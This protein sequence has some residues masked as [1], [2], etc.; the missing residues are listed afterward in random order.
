MVVIV[1]PLVLQSSMCLIALLNQLCIVVM[2]RGA[3]F[4]KKR[5]RM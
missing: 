5:G 3:N 1:E 2:W 4:D